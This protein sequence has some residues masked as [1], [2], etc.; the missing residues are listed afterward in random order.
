MPTDITNTRRDRA[1]QSG[2]TFRE[3]SYEIRRLWS[4]TQGEDLALHAMEKG[5]RVVGYNRREGRLEAAF[6]LDELVRKLEVPR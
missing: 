1:S 4:G 2:T 6:S 3:L 5:H